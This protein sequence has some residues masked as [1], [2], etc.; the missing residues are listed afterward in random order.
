VIRDKK[1]AKL[2]YVKPEVET[3]ENLKDAQP[4]DGAGAW[5][6][7]VG[8]RKFILC[9]LGILA[10]VV[11][12]MV[13]QDYPTKDVMENVFWLVV[14]GAGSIALEDGIGRAFARKG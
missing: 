13:R 7:N 3:V 8:G 10:C 11:V 9:A 5:V 4:A 6:D 14:A 2:K 1:K 12:A